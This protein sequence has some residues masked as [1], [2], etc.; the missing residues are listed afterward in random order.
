MPDLP[1]IPE[2]ITV[3]LGPPDSDAPNVTV[4]FLDYVANVASSEIYPTWPESAI[5]ANMYA[6]ISFALSRVFTE[7]Y[8]TLGYDFDITNSTA[9]DQYYVQ[10]R[11]V[12]SNIREL[13]GELFDNYIRRQGS[14]QPLFAQYCNGTTVTCPGLSQWGSVELA[15]QGYTPY[16]ILTYYYGD[17]IE[18]VRDAP[19]AGNQP[20]A[21]DVPLRL[22]AENDDVRIAQ[23]RLNRISSNFP[24]IPKI[25]R[26]DGV[27][28]TD[29]EAAVR[30]FQEI[31]SL[32][33]DG[34][35]GKST[36]YTIQNVYI[37][38]KRLN[39]INAEGITLQDVT[40]QYPGALQEGNRGNAVA[41]L[42]YFIAY[43]SQFYDT[44]PP[45]SI[46]GVFGATTRAAVEAVQRTFGL[47]VDGI[48]GE[49]TWDAL[50]RAYRGIVDTIP[51]EYIEGNALP[52]GGVPLRIGT[53]SGDV[54]LLQQYLNA[55]AESYTEIPTV[56][57][58]GYFGPRTEE[59]VIAL[60]RLVGIEPTGVVAA[61]TWTA[62][63]ELYDTL[64]IGGTLQSG[65]YPGFAVGR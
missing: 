12:F 48:V 44:I 27:F 7:Y 24:S 36:W 2:S 43:V 21:P 3:H 57:V 40:D 37:G 39:D 5:R 61:V 62:I 65:Q 34:V 63:A 55:I 38:V 25:A 11:D 6:Q 60:Q 50:Y 19:I 9:T 8:R 53:E 42:Q 51:R 52:Y 28:S 4:P 45:V 64:S 16:E 30:R 14:V 56:S 58:T 32:T 29:T 49:R 18:L 20:S 23:L 13:A 22:G 59:A 17:D 33:P 35:I 46:D 31:F 41:N 10:G 15:N 26:V 54:M 1:I 47:P